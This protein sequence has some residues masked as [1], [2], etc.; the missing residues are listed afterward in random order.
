MNQKI[1]AIFLAAIMV[2]SILPFFF[3]GNANDSNGDEIEDI[4]DPQD[5]PGFEIID[6]THFNA[7][8]NSISDGLAI[9]PQE[10][11]NNAAYI[12]Y[13]KVYGTPL[14]AF[15]PNI[16]NLYSVY[17][18]MIIK[19]YSAYGDDDFAFEAHVLSPEVV[20]F[21]YMAS[22]TYNG[23]QILSRGGEL[24]N[25][26]GTP[27][28][29]GKTNGLKKVVDVSSGISEPSPMY[30]EILE[31]VEPGA[32]YQMLSSEDLTADQHYI[33][34]KALENGDYS[35]TEVFLNPSD[36]TVDMVSALESNSTERGLVYDTSVEEDGRIL[37][38]V[39]TANESNF[40][41]LAMEKYY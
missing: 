27:T 17:N 41:N 4:N 29:L 35:R 21:Q 37:K 13:S 16:T 40:F 30:D 11:V 20:N 2:L 14:Q 25:I 9:T 22:E 7:E 36:S 32:E 39:V 1:V 24:Y 8:L 26:I 3:G 28:L 31:Y 19:R 12:D 10:G 33:E 6:G 18:T 5:A 34:F 23:Y 38:V 15:A